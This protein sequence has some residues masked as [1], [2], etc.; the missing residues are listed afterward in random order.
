MMSDGASRRLGFKLI[1]VSVALTALAALAVGFVAHVTT[2]SFS[3]SLL[4][5]LAVAVALLA[6]CLR[7][8]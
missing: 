3:M 5:A 7:P 8:R 2:L 4:A 1:T 6:P